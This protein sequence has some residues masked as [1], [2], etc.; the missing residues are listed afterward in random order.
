MK[1]QFI[2]KTGMFTLFALALTACSKNDNP[3]PP[4]PEQVLEGGFIIST[5][6]TG[7]DDA[8]YFLAATSLENEQDTIS[9][10][11]SGTEVNNIFDYYLS[12]G[13]SGFVSLQYGAVGVGQRFTLDAS[14]KVKTVGGRFELQ[15]GGATAVGTV[16]DYVYTI[17]N[18]RDAAEGTMNRVELSGGDPQYSTFKSDE[19]TGYEGKKAFLIDI[20]DSKDGFFYTSLHFSDNPEIDDVIIAKMNPT[21]LKAATIYTDPRLSVSGAFDRGA[22]FSQ[23]A[24]TDKGDAYIFSGNNF[25]TKKAGALVIRKG[26]S[27]FDKD[28]F[29]DIEAASGGYRFRKLWFIKD[30]KFLVEF[31]NDKFAAG[32]KTNGSGKACQYAVLD[33]SDKKFSWV[34][35]LPGKENILDKDNMATTPY[36]LQ[37]KAYLGMTVIDK[38]PQ[39][40]IVDPETASAKKG[41]VVKDA[42]RICGATFVENQ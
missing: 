26:A 19:F 3:A 1:K 33:M 4:E 32:E 5:E 2:K 14:G 22:R 41:L 6:A 36:I 40:Y 31:Y 25:G 27:S 29:W 21:T 15:G 17:R 37:G 16:G 35:G 7:V 11:G 24:T 18:S 34:S 30:D 10:K 13:Y 28:Y 12:F 9:P 42:Q 20:A 38:S 23:I 39:F 8:T